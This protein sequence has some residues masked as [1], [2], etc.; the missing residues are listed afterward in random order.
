MA[1]LGVIC[2]AC[3]SMVT[4]AGLALIAIGVILIIHKIR[5]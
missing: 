4:K 5:G 1:I 3:G 2:V